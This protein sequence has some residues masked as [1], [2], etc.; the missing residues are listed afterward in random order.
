MFDWSLDPRSK[1]ALLCL[2]TA[3]VFWNNDPL[4]FLFATMALCTRVFSNSF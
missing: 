2:V 3:F 1:L 4:F